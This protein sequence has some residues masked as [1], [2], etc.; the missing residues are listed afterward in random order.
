MVA[1]DLLERCPELSEAELSAQISA[2]VGH[3]EFLFYRV[4][5]GDDLDWILDGYEMFCTACGQH[6]FEPR[7]RK[8]PAKDYTYCPQ[9]G[10]EI[11]PKRWRDRA[12]LESIEFAYH[13]FQHGEGADV[14]LRSFQVSMDRN[15]MGRKYDIF[16][17]CRAL[18]QPGGAHKW[19]RSRSWYSGVSKW[20]TVKSICLKR[21]HGNYG[22]TRDDVWA[23]VTMEEMEG[24][25]LQYVPMGEAKPLLDDIVA[26]LA[27]WCKYPA[28]EYVW[29]MGFGAWFA[30]R[31]RGSDA[32]FHEWST[33]GQSGRIS[34]S[35]I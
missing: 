19:T 6:F 35:L 32:A 2:E 22:Q 8:H 30:Q 26:F 18:F 24:S 13:V 12:R 3:E 25:C 31:E 29:K 23:G 15:F 34:C 4:S 33:C 28:V 5:Q 27:L 21:W 1:L 17:Y 7:D 16:E 20:K 11:S 14:W 10:A 9:C